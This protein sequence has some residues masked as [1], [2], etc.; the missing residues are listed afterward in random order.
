MV[1]VTL[2]R[3]AP[4]EVTWLPGITI[5]TKPF[6]IPHPAVHVF[7]PD[8]DKSIR[9]VVTMKLRFYDCMYSICDHIN[10]KEVLPLLNVLDIIYMQ[11]ADSVASD[12]IHTV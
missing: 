11:V 3:T 4:N 10:G 8:S 6:L 2:Y 1:T 5:A 12:R 9:A 7:M